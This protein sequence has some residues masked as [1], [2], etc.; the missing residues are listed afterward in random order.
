MG[1]QGPRVIIGAQNQ[2]M[3]TRRPA[4]AFVRFAIA[5]AG[6]PSGD[7]FAASG[8]SPGQDAD[9]R[10]F[11]CSGSSP[12][13]SSAPSSIKIVLPPYL[14]QSQSIRGPPSRC[15]SRDSAANCSH[16]ES[17]KGLAMSGKYESTRFIETNLDAEANG[18]FGASGS[19]PGRLH[20][21]KSCRARTEPSDSV[22]RKDGLISFAD[23]ESLGEPQV[24]RR[25][26]AYTNCSGC[27][28]LIRRTRP[29][30]SSG[31]G[32]PRHFCKRCARRL[33]RNRR[34]VRNA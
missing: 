22:A 30:S 11:A 26:G 5:A 9:Q 16:V 10:A 27:Y 14:Q 28:R 34:V 33:G 32:M 4:R 15:P 24:L 13:L 19:S 12:G 31:A 23:L 2:A 1:R 8:S 7:A 3:I 21:E 18:F 6:S 17:E 25:T 29:I 20:A